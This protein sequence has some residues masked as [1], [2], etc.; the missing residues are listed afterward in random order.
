M[1]NEISEK[2]DRLSE[3]LAYTRSIDRETAAGVESRG[4][5]LLK[6]EWTN[7][8]EAKRPMSITA[9]RHHVSNGSDIDAIIYAELHINYFIVELSLEEIGIIN[10]SRR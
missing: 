3:M 5:T 7:D 10:A 4:H 1:R 6:I 9:L 2:V 8:I